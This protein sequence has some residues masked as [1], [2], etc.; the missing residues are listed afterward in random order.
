MLQILSPEHKEIATDYTNNQIKEV[1]HIDIHEHA[2]STLKEKIFH[3][4]LEKI[5]KNPPRP[6]KSHRS[7]DHVVKGDCTITKIKN[8]KNYSHKITLYNIGSFLEYQVHHSKGI[9]PITHLPNHPNNTNHP[10]SFADA[11][12]YIEEN[13]ENVI[14][15]NHEINNDRDVSL[16]NG[17]EWV[18]YFNNIPGFTPT[19]V[20]EINYDRYVFVIKKTKLNK[21]NKVVFYISTKEIQTDIKLTKMIKI[22]TGKKYK[23]VRFDID[24][25]S[26]ITGGA[27]N[28]GALV[29]GKSTCYCPAGSYI[30]T[31]G[32]N[33]IDLCRNYC[34]E[35]WDDVATFC[36]K[37]TWYGCHE[38]CTN[39]AGCCWDGWTACNNPNCSGYKPET[40]DPGSFGWLGSPSLGVVGYYCNNLGYNFSAWSPDNKNPP[41]PCGD[42]KPACWNS[43][44]SSNYCCVEPGKEMCCPPGSKCS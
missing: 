3:S 43:N 41:G 26:S 17:K 19:T 18:Q 28:G 25:G 13:A 37:T 24:Y 5:R 14:T 2:E 31:M 32:V 8:N 16:I 44:T 7:Y 33:W 9:V 6:S 11:T 4:N 10:T 21:D 36:W 22:P 38:S 1:I 23:N 29:G 42:M 20:M 34:K 35:G 12:K 27:C 15:V 40:Y 30:S 39:V